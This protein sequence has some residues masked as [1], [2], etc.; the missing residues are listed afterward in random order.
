MTELTCQEAVELLA[1]RDD[2]VLDAPVRERLDAH[3][4][5]CT[6]CGELDRSY[7]AIP[8]L[9]RT[10]TEVDIPQDSRDALRRFLAARK[11]RP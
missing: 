5:G 7:R 10:H 8:E 2:G 3:L 11:Q 4:A 6:P 9:F 1:E